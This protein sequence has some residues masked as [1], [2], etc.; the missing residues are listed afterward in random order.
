MHPHGVVP[1]QALL[2]AAFA[3]QYLRTPEHGT[4]YGFGGM[5]SVILYLPVLRTLSEWGPTRTP[6]LASPHL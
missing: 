2:W 5:A 4:V 6:M 3:D 1:I